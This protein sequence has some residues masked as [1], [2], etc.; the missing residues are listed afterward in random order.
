MFQY[1]PVDIN[2]WHCRWCNCM[3]FGGWQVL[4]FLRAS[5]RLWTDG[6]G[7]IN[8]GKSSLQLLLSMASDGCHLLIDSFIHDVLHVGLRRTS[9]T[10]TCV[11]AR[12]FPYL[13]SFV[14][15]HPYGHTECCGWVILGRLLEH[16]SSTRI[17]KIKI[18]KGKTLFQVLLALF[19]VVIG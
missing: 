15:P 7:F 19:Y 16:F 10:T 14:A 17:E 11:K 2:R 13:S 8:V 4:Y 3:L 12:C 1:D 18:L 9:Q 5:P 6:H